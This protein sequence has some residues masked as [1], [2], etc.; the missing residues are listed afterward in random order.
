MTAY[1]VINKQTNIVEN[2]IEWDGQTPVPH[3]DG[4]LIVQGDGGGIGWKW[5]GTNSIDLN[6]PVANTAVRK[7]SPLKKL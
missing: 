2:V 4:F 6:P 3:L 7:S 5:N 1:F